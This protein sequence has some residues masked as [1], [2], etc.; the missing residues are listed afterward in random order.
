MKIKTEK[1]PIKNFFI[2]KIPSI[3]FD[4]IILWILGINYR[5][6]FKKPKGNILEIHL[7]AYS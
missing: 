6:N 2:F 5:F 4:K 3:F 7:N 1:D